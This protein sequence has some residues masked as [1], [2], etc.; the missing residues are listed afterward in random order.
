MIR[1]LAIEPDQW[2][3]LGIL[4]VLRND[5]HAEFLVLGEPDCNKVLAF[6]RSPKDLKPDVVMLA[7][8]LITDFKLS[9]LERTKELFP[10][11]KV[12]VY[13]Y[14]ANIDN[15]AGLLAVGASGY[16]LLSSAPEELAA[17]LKHVNRGL[18]WGPP[19]AVAL[20]VERMRRRDGKRLVL[21]SEHLV[22]P[23]ELTLLKFLKEGMGNKEIA[24]KLGVAEVTIK[25]HLAK[26]YRRFNLHTRLQLLSYAINHNLI[27]EARPGSRSAS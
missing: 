20:M 24:C 27:L 3:Y 26:L 14:Q 7:R 25:S 21:K 22:T 10:N 5:R 12:L 2:R 16:F 17:A 8:S 9:V 13:G 23:A 1:V 19:E 4:N 15:I 6:R 11:A 18:I